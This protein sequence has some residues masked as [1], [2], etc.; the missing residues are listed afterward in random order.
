[1]KPII[2]K[3]NE[4]AI[5]YLDKNIS[6]ENLSFNDLQFDELDKIELVMRLEEE[7]DVQITD[8]ESDSFVSI[9][10]VLKFLDKKEIKSINQL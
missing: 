5:K 7:F 4:I 9:K 8:E 3:I 6:N 2:E 10:D 1:M